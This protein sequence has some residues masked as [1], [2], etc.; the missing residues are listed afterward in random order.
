MKRGLKEYRRESL[1]AGSARYNR[2]PDEK[3]TESDRGRDGARER[4]LELQSFPDEKG[5]ERWSNAQIARWA[6]VG[7]NRFPDEKGTERKQPP[8]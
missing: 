4:W 3:G 2:F 5:T 6:Q 1:N 8:R 7:Y